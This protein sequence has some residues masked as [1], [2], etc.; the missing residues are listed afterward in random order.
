MIVDRVG[1][2]HPV[3]PPRVDYSLTPLG[4]EVAAH[5]EALTDW[6]EGNLDRVLRA[7]E[8]AP[9]RARARSTA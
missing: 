4:Q 5:V 1:E 2:V 7:R 9:A 8:K 6:I 3:I